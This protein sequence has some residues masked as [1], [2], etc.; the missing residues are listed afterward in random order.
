MRQRKQSALWPAAPHTIAKIA[1]LRAYLHAWFQIMGRTMVGKDLLYV[2]GFAGPGAYA[3]YPTGSPIAAVEAARSVIEASAGSWVADNIHCAFIEPDPERFAHLRENLEPF[4]NVD[5]LKLHLFNSTFVDGLSALRSRIPLPFRMSHPLFTFIDPFGATGAPFSVVEDILRSSRSEI[6]L[7]LDADGIARIY[8]AG[9]SADHETLLDRVFG[10]SSWKDML[11]RNLPF[12]TLCARSLD[13]YKTR[14]RSLPKVRYVFAFEMRT[15]ADTLNYYLV[16]ASQHPKGLEKMKEAMKSIDQTGDYCFTDAFTEQPT[17]FRFDDVME[18]SN[19]LLEC[20]RGRRA[21]WDSVNDYA[22][23][24]TPFSNPK[25]MLKNLEGQDLISVA[26]SD[27][28]RRK[29]T[30]NEMKI[31]YIQFGHGA[32]DGY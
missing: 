14:L 15:H 20:F 2:D 11:S 13:L 10:D 12:P 29:G 32:D 8:Q 1:I 21:F 26:S 7:N 31:Q 28:K 9:V 22:L 27:P 24:E 23:N 16:F 5:K 19:R 3:N 30:F 4:Q 6:L 25:G 18:W 17:L